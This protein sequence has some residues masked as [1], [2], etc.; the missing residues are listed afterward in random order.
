MSTPGSTSERYSA[1]AIVLHWAIAMAIVGNI[2]LGWWMHDAIGVQ[3]TQA[4]AVHAYQLHKSIGFTILALSLMRLAWR[5]THPAPVLPQNMVVWERIVAHATHWALYVLMV[6]L[7]LTGWLYVS[8]GWAT[9]TD[10]PLEVPTLYFGLFEIPHLFGLHHAAVATRSA[11]ASA[12]LFTH[13]NLALATIFVLLP[14]HVIGGLKHH[15]KDRDD[16]LS[17]MVPGLNAPGQPAPERSL[18]RSIAIGAGLAAVLFAVVATTLSW[19][20]GPDTSAAP[21]TAGQSAPRAVG[22]SAT[23]DSAP[24]VQC[25][26]STTAWRVDPAQSEIA[27]TGTHAGTDFRGRFGT[28]RADICFDPADLTKSSAVVTVDTASA[29]DGVPLHDSSLPSEE[30]F[31]VENHPTATFR[32]TAFQKAA[33]GDAYTA[34]G[35]LALKGKDIPVSLPFTLTI[36]GDTARI[37]GQVQMD[38]VT[39]DLGL[40]SD[41]DADWVSRE[42]GLE[43]SVVAMKG[44]GAE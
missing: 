16:V 40:E 8:T 1:V 2:L 31:D 23:L 27:F 13:A 6:G 9:P 35:V 41:P 5:L 15:F 26:A 44:S 32:V 43:V 18:G 14:L 33:A 37:T 19:I 3:E 10:R 11:V 38:R 36:S 30:W 29:A 7:P 17:R 39:A 21:P 24:A 20:H 12:A 42:I 34:T 4:R 28:W 25:A 22:T